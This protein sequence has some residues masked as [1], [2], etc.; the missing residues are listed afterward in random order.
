V[1]LVIG[2]ALIDFFPASCGKEE[3]YIPRPGGS[4]HNVAI[5]LGRLG[6]P[7]GFVGRLSR[8]WFGR[9][10]RKS[11]ESSG[12]DLRYLMEGDEP[13]ALS[14]IHLG[15]AEPEFSFYGDKTA[16]CMLTTFPTPLPNEVRAIHVGSLAMV[17]EPIGTAITAF[18]SREHGKRIISFDPNV[19]PNQISDRDA[20]LARFNRW[21]QLSDIVKASRSDLDYLY[22]D[23]DEKTVTARWLESGVRLVVITHGATGATGYVGREVVKVEGERITAVDT[24]GAGDAFTS[25]LLAWLHEHNRLLPERLTGISTEEF[26]AALKWASRVAAITCARRGADPPHRSELI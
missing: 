22:P 25:G 13:T 18:L 19:R 12:V 23:E 4:P 2:E 17:R 24:V 5:G 7:V 10:L 26:H 14:F 1:I 20:Y 9:L 15:G 11:F 8:D 21:L 16:D 6:V 3:G